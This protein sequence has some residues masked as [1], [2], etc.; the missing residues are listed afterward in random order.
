MIKKIVLALAA[1]CAS[2]ALFIYVHYLN[3]NTDYSN[4]VEVEVQEATSV[5]FDRYGVPHVYAQ[6][7]VDAYWAMGYVTASERYF[8]ADIMRRIGK[9][10]LS[11][12]FGEATIEADKLFRTLGIADH[13]KR[14]IEKLDKNAPFYQY[15]TAYLKGF[16]QWVEEGH[17]PLEYSILGVEKEKLDMTDLM[18]ISAYM[19]YNFNGSMKND[20]F[21]HQ[22]WSDLGEDYMAVFKDSTWQIPNYGEFH[23]EISIDMKKI[24]EVFESLPF[25]P[26]LASN[27]WAVSG[28][29]SKSGKV[30]FANDTHIRNSLPC[31]WYEAHINYPGHNFYGN[32]LPGIP[33]AL[34]GHSEQH[35][36]GLTMLKN[37]D[38]DFFIEHCND[39]LNVYLNN[40][41]WHE[42]DVRNES[43]AVKDKENIELEIKK[44]VH[45]PLVNEFIHA[46]DQEPISFHWN[47]LKFPN[48]LL[49]VFHR[50]N[51]FHTLESAQEAAS[52]IVAPG[53]NMV[54]GNNKGDIALWS[55]AKLVDRDSTYS[56]VFLPGTGEYD[57]KNYL[58]FEYNYKS[59]NPEDG[60]VYSANED[61]GE[62]NN[63]RPQGDYSSD[64]RA[65]A[66]SAYLYGKASFD[67]E[68]F[69]ELVFSVEDKN[70]QEV[71]KKLLTFLED[72]QYPEEQEILEKWKGNYDK[73]N[74]APILYQNW[75]Y[76]LF[77]SIF[78]DEL[79]A[80][81]FARLI[82]RLEFKKNYQ[83]V[84]FNHENI[85]WKNQ[86]HSLSQK[87][88]IQM[89]FEQAIGNVKDKLGEESEKW[90]WGN[91]HQAFFEHPI[92]KQKPL[93]KIFTV[94]PYPCSGNATTI[95]ANSFTLDESCNYRVFSAPQ[96]RIIVDFADVANAESIL[97]VGQSGNPSSDYFDNQAKDFL[98]GLWRTMEMKEKSEWK[99]GKSIVFKPIK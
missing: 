12:V 39:E 38:S 47:Y 68:D 46:E 92:G 97:P 60:I 26:L 32:F 48:N 67:T 71:C 25:D 79:G 56:Q 35:T 74:R 88:L 34:I 65:N 13:A 28:S 73:N 41:E 19:A 9:G 30:L 90:N 85:W 89:A 24:D 21:I 36:W 7:A 18:A 29:K 23:S 6:N 8:Q 84:I 86:A 44:S 59:I 82:A 15:T 64:L 63:H 10:R 98:N 91:C 75:K 78:E 2:I 17:T 27:S 53:V 58:D 3:A 96:M 72:S 54:Y 94:G 20:P 51:H 42:F 52:M 1:I 43:I 57:I 5:H 87:E 61:H 76:F 33:F 81:N 4:D 99:S 50:L 69:K 31:T 11:E 22:L 95:N 66:I 77:K 37:D 45:G 93:D 40:N 70:D 16:N 49:E 14:S 83:K 80:D 55:C 62:F